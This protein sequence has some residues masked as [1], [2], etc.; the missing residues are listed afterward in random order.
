MAYVDL[1]P[2]RAALCETLEDS[3]HTS[4]RQRLKQHEAEP[5][6]GEVIAPIAGVGGQCAVG[7][8][9]TDYLQLLDWTGR[10]VHPNKR[11]TLTG[12]P[13]RALQRMGHDAAQWPRQVLVVGSDF[14]RAVGAAES[15]IAK[16]AAMGQ[17]WLHGIGVARSL[18]QANHCITR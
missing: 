10:R 13:P 18:L 8:T 6:A 1:N 5:V 12:P 4:A 16:A 14:R 7:I 15:L 11:G 2:V 3:A 9:A 17:R